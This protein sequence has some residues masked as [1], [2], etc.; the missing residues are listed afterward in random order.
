MLSHYVTAFA[1]GQIS[2]PLPDPKV[3]PATH[4]EIKG[5]AASTYT[6]GHA[7]RDMP[8]CIIAFACSPSVNVLSPHHGTNLYG[9]S[10]AAVAAP[11]SALA[12]CLVCHGDKC[13]LRG[14]GGNTD[15]IASTK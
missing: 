6:R 14:N 7:Q 3:T 13:M 2:G 5:C 1:Y 10:L 11:E 9:P 8:G 15:C 4:P 12:L